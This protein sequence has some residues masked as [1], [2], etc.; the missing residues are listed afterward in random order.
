MK[1]LF[2]LYF[3]GSTMLLSCSIQTLPPGNLISHIDAKDGMLLYKQSIVQDISNNGIEA[4]IFG[5][6][7]IDTMLKYLSYFNSHSTV[8]SQSS[9][10]TPVKSVRVYLSRVEDSAAKNFNDKGKSNYKNFARY[11]MFFVPVVEA[12]VPGTSNFKDYCLVYYAN[13]GT[14]T[15]AYL[16]D[17][18]LGS[19]IGQ[20]TIHTIPLSSGVN[21]SQGIND[22]ILD[23]IWMRPPPY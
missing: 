11:K 23:E 21:G 3:I 8:L 5:E 7:S 18:W 14:S 12:M 4:P 6:V 16:T 17:E 22:V 19:S 1:K 20:S 9:N 2:L 13:S 15:S 10:I